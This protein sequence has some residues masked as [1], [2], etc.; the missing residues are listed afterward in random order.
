MTVHPNWEVIQKIYKELFGVEPEVINFIAVKDILRLCC[1]GMSSKRISSEL[2]VG[3]EYVTDVLIEYFDFGGWEETLEIN[4]LSLYNSTI[5]FS[6]FVKYIEDFAEDSINKNL[7][8]AAY[9]MCKKYEKLKE[10]LKN[11]E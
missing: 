2:F 4:P 7:I 5:E 10:L 6:D 1:Y 11:Y 3:E 8:H 9:E